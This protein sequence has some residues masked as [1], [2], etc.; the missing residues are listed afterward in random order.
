MERQFPEQYS[1][2]LVS[3]LKTISFGTPNVVGSSADHRIMYSAD[4]DLIEDVVLSK[5]TTRQFKT[6]IRKIQMKSKI[7]DIKIG[8][9][10]EWNLLTKPFILN[11]IV[12][13]YNQGSEL[14]HLSALWNAKIITHDEFMAAQ[15]LLTPHLT[16]PQF[17][18]VKKELR[19]GLM[20]WTIKEVMQGHKEMRGRLVYLED[21]L[22]SKGITKIDVVAWIKSKYVEISNIIIWTKSNGKPYPHLPTIKKTLSEDILLFATEGQYI[23]MAKRM[24][25]LAK[26]YKNHTDIEKLTEILNSPLGKLYMVISDM[27]ILE[28]FPNA[29]TQKRKRKEL[30]LMRDSFA[31]LF[32]PELN[33][34]VPNLKL[35][36]KMEEVLESEG[37]KVLELKHLLPIPRDYRI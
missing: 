30:D 3:I 31:K 18:L 36:P 32:F 33:S 28:E 23:K 4:Y 8:E 6:K 15:T 10:T 5:R 34:A 29:I 26:Q 22:K 14:Q 13:K 17:L 27:R 9:I 20:R 35:L 11:G 24:L 12:K 16:A 19:F 25:S 21:A 7:V 37:K 2:E 1:S